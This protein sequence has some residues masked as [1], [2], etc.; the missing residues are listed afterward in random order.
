[1]VDHDDGEED[2]TRYARVVLIA[3][4]R[5]MT[6]NLKLIKTITISEELLSNMSNPKIC[7][8]NDIGEQNHS[9]VSFQQ[10][11]FNLSGIL[12]V[13]TFLNRGSD[14]HRRFLIT[15]VTNEII[16]DFYFS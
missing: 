14:K 12:I 13:D 6:G 4:N 9:S 11:C 8:D 16:I 5:R 15:R 1:V 3:I 7:K 2:R 10:S